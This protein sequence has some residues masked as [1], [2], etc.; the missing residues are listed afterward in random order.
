MIVFSPILFGLETARCGL[1]L[2]FT[3]V[4]LLNFYENVFLKSGIVHKIK[5]LELLHLSEIVVVNSMFYITVEIV[6]YIVLTLN[7]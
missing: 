1:F 6:N 7:I 5:Y 3:M 2:T 4:L